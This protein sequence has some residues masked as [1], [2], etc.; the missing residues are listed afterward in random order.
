LER[1]DF[2]IDHMP[3]A[4]KYDAY[5]YEQREH[6]NLGPE[7]PPRELFKR[8]IF[9]CFIDDR[10]G[11][12]NLDV[13]GADNVMIETDY[14]HGDGTYPESVANAERLLKEFDDETR[15]KIMQGNARRVF[16]LTEVP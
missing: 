16:N 3:W 13:M 14:P 12:R 1:A 10:F 8:H 2:I 15:Y 6:E 9:G 11:L 7:L 5:D 4:R